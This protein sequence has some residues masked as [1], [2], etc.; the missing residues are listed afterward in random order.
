MPGGAEGPG[1]T[2]ALELALEASGYI[3]WLKSRGGAE[4]HDRE[5]NIHELL[6]AC[7]AAEEAGT[8]AGAFL[9]NAALM[10]DVDRMAGE[11]SVVALMTMHNAK[12]LEFEHVFLCGLEEG[13]LPHASSLGDPAELEEERRLMYVGLTR[14]RVTATLTLARGRRT[15]ERFQWTS[16]S[17]FL[18]EIPAALVESAG[19]L[20][21]A[22][23]AAPAPARTDR[24]DADPMP[25]YDTNPDEPRFK[26][27]DKVF[28][29]RFGPGRVVSAGQ[30]PGGG[31]LVVSFS[32][33]GRKTLDAGM[34][35]LSRIA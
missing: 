30:G 32:R 1:F 24:G 27:G 5:E 25:D 22:P 28:H 10:A 18:S 19:G 9:E 17:R 4:A 14:A 23:A 7:R 11:R 33:F 26:P 29:E 3:E 21:S 15:F 8:G 2:S 35:R 12:G 16:A 34:A 6:G 31:R 20:A 13:L